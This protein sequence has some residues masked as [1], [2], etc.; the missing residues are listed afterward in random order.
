MAI[1]I[2]HIDY[3]NALFVRL[4]DVDIKKLQAVQNSTAK[5]V[6]GKAKYNSCTHCFG[7]LHWL[8]VKFRII[9]KIL[10]MVHKCLNSTVPQYLI[11]L[12]TEYIPGRDGFQ[13]GGDTQRMVVP[14]SKMKTFAARSF[15]VKGPELWN[16]LPYCIRAIDNFDM[17]KRDLKTYLFREAFELYLYVHK[18]ILLL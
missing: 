15:S 8:S 7:T 12:L 1:V 2:S 3:T 17:F 10:T 4:P 16:A 9:F 18:F 14:V 13:S 6:L 5:L 11:N